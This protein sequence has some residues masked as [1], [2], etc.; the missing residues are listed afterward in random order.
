MGG[1]CAIV[2]EEMQRVLLIWVICNGCSVRVCGS[3]RPKVAKSWKKLGGFEEKLGCFGSVSGGFR[4]FLRG[5]FQ[6]CARCQI[7]Q[8]AYFDTGVLRDDMAASRTGTRRGLRSGQ[9]LVVAF[10]MRFRCFR[11]FS[12]VFSWHLH[13]EA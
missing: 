5:D 4:S 7:V 11:G 10:L 9:R 6:E 2:A 13:A 12:G 3:G 8:I 1:V